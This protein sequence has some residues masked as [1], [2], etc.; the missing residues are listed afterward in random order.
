MVLLGMRL[1]RCEKLVKNSSSLV[2]VAG[3][4]TEVF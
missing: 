4:G 1:S 3:E 2:D